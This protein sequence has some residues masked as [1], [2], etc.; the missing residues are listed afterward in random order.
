MHFPA[1]DY[2]RILP[3]EKLQ[4]TQSSNG[5]IRRLQWTAN[6]FKRMPLLLTLSSLRRAEQPFRNA[7][8]IAPSG[9]LR[10]RTTCE[11]CDANGKMRSKLSWRAFP[12]QIF[13]PTT[14]STVS[15]VLYDFRE[16]WQSPQPCKLL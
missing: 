8:A 1:R 12:P 3:S 13:Q 9:E 16:L 2:P 7:L 11:W 4:K 6:E 10:T 5:V 14:Q 15:G